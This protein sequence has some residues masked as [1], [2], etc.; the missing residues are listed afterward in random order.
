MESI[1][2]LLLKEDKT[3]KQEEDYN[4]K[5]LKVR[6]KSSLNKI[7]NRLHTTQKYMLFNNKLLI[8]LIRSN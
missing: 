5:T 3:E 4:V 8:T 1:K 2:E 7:C 6:I